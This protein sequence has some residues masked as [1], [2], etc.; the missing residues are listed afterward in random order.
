MHKWA[1][2]VPAWGMRFAPANR[3]AGCQLA[4]GRGAHCLASIAQRSR[5]L[6]RCLP[7]PLCSSQDAREWEVR[8]VLDL[9]VVV[10]SAAARGRKGQLRQR[11]NEQHAQLEVLVDWEGEE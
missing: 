9:R 1:R 10:S 11:L 7:C 6:S 2:D 3:A 8:G 4:A 5:G